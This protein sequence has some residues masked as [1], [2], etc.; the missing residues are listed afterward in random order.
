MKFSK[1]FRVT[2]CLEL[3]FLLFSCSSKPEITDWAVTANNPAGIEAFVLTGPGLNAKDVTL[4][5]LSINASTVGSISD[6]VNAIR[7]SGYPDPLAIE[8]SSK[9]EDFT[10]DFSTNSGKV[11]GLF[12]G[13]NIQIASK[14]FL[15]LP[16]Y[17]ELI[18]HIKVDIARFPGGQERVF[19]TRNGDDIPDL[20]SFKKYQELLTGND[21]SNYISLCRDLKI[22]AEP[23]INIYNYDEVMESSLIDQIVKGLGYDLKYISAGNEP[24]INAFSNWNYL[25]SADES[26]A[27]AAYTHRY[28]SYSKIL[29]KIKPDITFV[30][31]EL[32]GNSAKDLPYILDQLKGDNPGAVSVHWYLLGD[33]GESPL[34]PGYPS[35]NHLSVSGN[36]GINISSLGLM[37][38]N[39]KDISGRYFPHIRLFVGEWGA[40]WSATMNTVDIHDTL[41]TAIFTAEVHEYAKN[42]GYDCIEYFGLSDPKNFY[43]WNPALIAVDGDNFTVRPQYYIRLIYKYLWGDCIVEVRDARSED[44]SIYASSDSNYNYLMLI[45]RTEKTTFEKIVKVKTMDAVK[46]YRIKI[47]PHAVTVLRLRAGNRRATVN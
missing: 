22:A 37:Y 38:S 31:G 24:N 36:N 21:V 25:D 40:S 29:R 23:E 30:L 32:G 6:S 13:I 1:A 17:R 2:L 27:V 4:N 18:R 19:Y 3:F 47:L 28:L 39:M 10:A 8:V 41:A 20:G 26:G 15:T 45:N 14:R 46:K 9:S 35:I 16:K 44:Y 5:G 11:P 12:Y 33:W 43:P 42:T 34:Y 7:R